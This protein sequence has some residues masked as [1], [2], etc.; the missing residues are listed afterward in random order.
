MLVGDPPFTGS[1]AQAIIARHLT[2]PPPPI[3]TVRTDLDAPVAAAVTRGLSKIPAERFATTSEFAAALTAADT[4]RGATRR[5]RRTPLVA[6]TFTA[7]LILI[8]VGV[9]LT[10]SRG[11]AMTPIVGQVRPLTTSTDNELNPTW[12][13]DGRSVAFG[14]TAKGDMDLFVMTLGGEARQI[15]DHP[16]DEVGP[17]WSPLG[18]KIA[19]MSDRGEGANVYWVTPT[20][21]RERLVAR[22][23]VTMLEHSSVWFR[24]LG[25]SPWSPDG[26]RLLF[27]RMGSAG[28]I[29]V[30][31]FDFESL[32]ETQLTYPGGGGV[33]LGASWS[34]TGNEIVF[35]RTAG[36]TTG[37]WMIPEAGEEAK[38]LLQDGNEN[39][40]ATWMPNGQ[41]ILFVSRRLGPLGIFQMDLRSGATIGTGLLGG[42]IYHIAV[43]TRGDVAYGVSSHH[44]DLFMGSVGQPSDAHVNLTASEADHFGADVNSD[45]SRLIFHATRAGNHDLWVRDL[46]TGEEAPLTDHPGPDLVPS[47]SP[48]GDVVF[49]SDRGG[50]LR[51]W[52]LDAGA[53]QPRLLRDSPFF[54]QS[55]MAVV[56]S[57]GPR[58]SPDGAVIG[59]LA[60]RD[61]VLALWTI[62]PD[63]SNE[64]ATSLVDVRGF[65]WYLDGNRVVYTTAARD[66]QSGAE[67]RVANLRTGE[68]R[69]LVAGMYG[70]PTVAT[71]GTELSVESSVSHYRSDAFLLRLRAPTSPDGLP[72]AVGEPQRLTDGGG[73]WHVHNL[74]WLPDGRSFIYTRDE[75]RG[76]IWLLE[77][78]R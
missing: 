1:T 10:L 72:T 34:P 47:W 7:G 5:A 69:L 6:A 66:G 73:R 32:E 27:P 16:A 11:P 31:M 8:T 18:D 21:G 77:A 35:D 74:A 44:A 46:N 57:R 29:A 3:A 51:L 62:S 19:F 61:T 40:G 28:E 63:G 4:T 71:T 12:S 24:G 75:D 54:L 41:E 39:F 64:R 70:E 9:A 59:F 25:P 36:E 38:P 50:Q 55:E 26:R 17:R 78:Q 14:R 13:P 68:D 56:Y 58:W 2:D 30:W 52:V 33:D 49:A 15:T 67:I 20:G 43:S 45:G 48:D 53:N 23:G 22:T 37:L 76:D 65:D 42:L 60:P